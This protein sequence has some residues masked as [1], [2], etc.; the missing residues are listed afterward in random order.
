MRK[1]RL[2]FKSHRTSDVEQQCAQ[3]PRLGAQHNRKALI[4]RPTSITLDHATRDARHRHPLQISLPGWCVFIPWDDLPSAY[5]FS[6]LASWE[7]RQ[8]AFRSF[9][10]QS[11][12]MIREPRRQGT[13][14]ISRSSDLK[15]DIGQ[16]A[17]IVP[18]LRAGKGVALT[19][20]TLKSTFSVEVFWNWRGTGKFKPNPGGFSRY[21]RKLRGLGI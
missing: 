10:R 9:N 18:N 19:Y 6:S 20:E 13:V 2:T 8:L 17:N 11:E 21:Q 7:A 15:G 3:G 1:L 4:L 16:M 14:C 5:T 12:W